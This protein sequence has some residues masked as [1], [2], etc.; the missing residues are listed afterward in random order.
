M[1]ID[2]Y[3]TI[4]KETNESI[5]Q[6][7]QLASTI[8]FFSGEQSVDK[9]KLLILLA[10]YEYDR[11]LYIWEKVEP[12]KTIIAIGNKPTDEKF[13]KRNRKVVEELSKIINNCETV[14]ISANDPFE[15]QREIECLINRHQEHY[16]VI[17]SP[18]NTKLQTL[19]LY[20]A[21]EKHP[22]TQIIYSRPEAFSTWLTKGVKETLLFALE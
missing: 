1:K 16:N 12:S 8:P 13:F 7:A 21:W 5:S 20:L 18:M 19:G 15:A 3:Y 22:E 9:N 10:G 2:C 14:E 11:A 17:I 6:F 4:P